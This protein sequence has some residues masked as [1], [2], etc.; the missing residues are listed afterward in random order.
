MLAL[1]ALN[2]VLIVNC[3]LESWQ[4][5]SFGKLL[6]SLSTMVFFWLE[7]LHESRSEQP[8]LIPNTA[9]AVDSHFDIALVQQGLV[10]IALFQLT[11]FAGYSLRPQ[12]RSIIHWAQGRVD[13]PRSQML[14]IVLFFAA[15]AVFPLL[16]SFGGNL[17]EVGETLL[18]GRSRTGP[19]AEDI[20]Y[21]QYL[22]Y[23]GLFGS[24]LLLAKGALSKEK[25]RRF[26]LLLGILSAL[27]FVMVSGSRHLWLYIALPT[28]VISIR[29]F[30]GGTNPGRFLR[31]SVL[32][33]VVLLVV[34]LQFAL[35][36]HGWTKTSYVSTQQIFQ[37]G[38]TG[39]F[40]A[41]LY[42]EYL[43]PEFHGYFRE[44]AEPYFVTH[45]IPRAIWP[46]KKFMQSWTYYNASYTQGL[47]FNVTPSVIGQFYINWGV[48]GVAFIGVWLGFLTYLAD[49]ILS[50]LNIRRQWAMAAAVGMLYAFVCSSFRI[51]YPIY[52]VYFAFGFVGMLM[53]TRR[54]QT[55]AAETQHASSFARGLGLP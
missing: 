9:L 37:T 2:G 15:C 25:N 8:F 3:F 55:Q 40:T 28:V 36:Q 49:R 45:F 7:A 48:A 42:A 11:L 17:G 38:T 29:L 52:F 20:G 33:L 27:P 32:A 6:L 19:A 54:Q 1:V 46:E 10:F 43:V 50:A 44:P 12:L 35:R 5:R 21:I 41:L 18:A 26:Y 39:Q 30:G 31:I 23:L 51:Y 14:P 53:L 13:K 34:Q 4:T 16:L 24:A 22:Y 47:K